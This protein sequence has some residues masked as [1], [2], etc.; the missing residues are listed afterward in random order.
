[1]NTS[2]ITGFRDKTLYLDEH[3]EL[4]V[5][6]TYTDAVKKILAERL[7]AGKDEQ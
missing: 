1:V 5:S 3:S 4:P 6:R 2:R 7:F